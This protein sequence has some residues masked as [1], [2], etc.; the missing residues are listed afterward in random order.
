M[1]ITN[2]PLSVNHL[3]AYLETLM[4]IFITKNDHRWIKDAESRSK[5]TVRKTHYSLPPCVVVEIGRSN[6]YYWLAKQNKIPF[7][8][9][10]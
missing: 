9:S 8:S 2:E 6:P 1:L 5:F 3:F 7:T 10:M 4:A